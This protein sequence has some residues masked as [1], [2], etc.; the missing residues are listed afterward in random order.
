MEK[1]RM[2]EAQK[3]FLTAQATVKKMNDKFQSRSPHQNVWNID[4]NLI[5]G[6]DSKY[7]F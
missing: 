7:Y 5:F 2:A 1:Q 4:F 3:L 6:L